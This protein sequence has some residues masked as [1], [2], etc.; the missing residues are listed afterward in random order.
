MDLMMPIMVLKNQHPT[1]AP[2]QDGWMDGW[3]NEWMDGWMNNLSV[4]PD[5]KHFFFPSIPD[6]PANHGGG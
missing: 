6:Q 2:L 1:K 5:K 3:M 4:C